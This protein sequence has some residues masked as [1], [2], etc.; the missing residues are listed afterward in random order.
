MKK[1]EY[2][3]ET[4]REMWTR[5]GFSEEEIEEKIKARKEKTSKSLKEL[6]SSE[7]GKEILIKRT[8][9]LSMKLKGQKR[10][11]ET[12][13]K[14]SEANKKYRKNN[15]EKSRERYVKFKF[16]MSLK[17]QEEKKI[18]NMKRGK[19]IKAAWS[20][21]KNAKSYEERNKKLS[22]VNKGKKR[23]EE[24]K[25]KQSQ[26]NTGKK[27]SEETKI[28]R[29]KTRMEK[30]AKG[31]YLG[32]KCKMYNIV[33]LSCQGGSEKAYIEK[34]IKENKPLPQKAMFVS[35]PLGIYHPDFEYSDKYIE[36]KS[37]FTYKM[38]NGEITNIDNHI[39]LNQKEKATWVSQ[40]IK[41]VELIVI[42]SKGKISKSLVL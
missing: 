29:A 26:T 19:S 7:K 2:R 35:T 22:E 32:V 40:N 42:D 21:P 41:P 20:D 34:L 15:P 39:S 6:W 31:E 11:L 24:S 12:R 3:N 4:L 9:N 30:M 38:F 16:T 27:Q 8:P 5:K 37:D 18:T 10:S 1:R 14:M 25:R 28:K 13:K 17:T 33:G 36:I 23:S